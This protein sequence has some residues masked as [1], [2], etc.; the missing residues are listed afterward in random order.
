MLE[1]VSLYLGSRTSLIRASRHHSPNVQ[2]GGAFADVL[3]SI[4]ERGAAHGAFTDGFNAV[5]TFPRHVTRLHDEGAN[6]RAGD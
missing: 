6:H 4:F 1:V 5:H 2:V 3:S